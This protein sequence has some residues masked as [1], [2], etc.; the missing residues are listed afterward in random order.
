MCIEFR[1]YVD[2]INFGRLETQ[3]AVVRVL[4]GLVAGMIAMKI[5]VAETFIVEAVDI[6]RNDIY[7]E[8]ILIRQGTKN[9]QL[10]LGC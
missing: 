1:V 9:Y 10:N 6:N 7:R 5:V 2:I 3:K 4:I 8:M